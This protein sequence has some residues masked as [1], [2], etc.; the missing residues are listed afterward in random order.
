MACPHLNFE[1]HCEVNS[2]QKDDLHPDEIVAYT[3]DVRTNCRDCGQEFEFFGIPN[4]MSFYQPTMSIDAKRVCIPMVLP[5]TK[6]PL[7]LAG[8]S[9]S[10]T[11]YPD[12]DPVAN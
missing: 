5:G 1:C 7:G 12:K 11:E 3:L 6:P 9:V 8:Y 10:F 4:G 2:I